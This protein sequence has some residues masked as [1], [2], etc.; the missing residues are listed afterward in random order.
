MRQADRVRLLLQSSGVRAKLVHIKT[1]GDRGVF[2]AGDEPVKGLFTKELESAL[3]DERIDMAV[4]S[5]KDLLTVQPLGLTLAAF[6]EREDP[7][8]ALVTR[9]DETLSAL[10]A[11]SRIGTSSLRRRA[12]LQA[13]RP[14][15]QAVPLS[16]NVPRRIRRVDNGEIDGAVLA[17]A[18]LIRLD[19]RDRAQPL[20]PRRFVPAAGQGALAVQVRTDDTS[21]L[22]VVRALDDHRVR[23]A[24]EAERAALRWLEGGCKAPVG[25]LCQDGVL[26]VTVYAPDG[27][28]RISSEIVVDPRAPERAGQQ[29]ARDLLKRG[30]GEFIAEHTRN[31]AAQQESSP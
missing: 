27:S 8:D 21:I 19:R 14:D 6:P 5:L 1:A 26:Q 20:D 31:E 9:T 12:A 28:R 10:P 13:E 11:G 4:H 15:L 23:S 29:A 30:A 2:L 17:L 16:G 7:R 24:V 3:L 22:Q 18:G 25:A